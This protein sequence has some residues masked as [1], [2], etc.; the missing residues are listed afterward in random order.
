MN[1]IF[2]FWE[3]VLQRMSGQLQPDT[4]DLLMRYVLPVAF[5]EEN[6]EIVL[7]VSKPFFKVWLSETCCLYCTPELHNLT[8]NEIQVIITV[9][10]MPWLHRLNHLFRHRQLLV[11]RAGGVSPAGSITR[12]G[13]GAGNF[14]TFTTAGS[15]TG[16]L[17]K[18]E[19][20]PATDNFITCRAGNISLVK[21][22]ADQV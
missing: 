3:Q 18:H 15:K 1:T 22:Q 17:G 21:L 10:N 4:I 11:E 2:D 16:R 20:Y 19:Q 12:S 13:S 8:G 9:P 5:H 14:Q 6:K 7:Q